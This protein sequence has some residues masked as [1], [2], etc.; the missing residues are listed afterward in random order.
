IADCRAHDIL[1]DSF[2]LSSGYTSIGP[3]RYVFTWNRDKFPD[4]A[5]FAK[6]YADAGV[7]LCANIKPCLLDDHPLLE[8]AHEKG[9]LVC[10][11]DGAPAWAQFWDGLG[12]YLD[13]T[14]PAT[15]AWWR[16]QVT[17]AL[18]DNGIVSTWNDNNE[19]EIA[20]ATA[21]ANLFGGG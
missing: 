19:F 20:S 21:R 5:A 15:Q 9:L 1:C 10:E 14:N 2:H 12:A 4:P 17:R 16:A 18:L 6:S 7:R 11:G 8:E 13:F 3:R